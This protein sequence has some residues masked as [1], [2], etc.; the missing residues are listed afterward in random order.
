MLALLATSNGN[1]VAVHTAIRLLH[2]EMH[3]LHHSAETDKIGSSHT[4]QMSMKMMIG[5]GCLA[6]Q[7]SQSTAAT[8][9]TRVQLVNMLRKRGIPKPPM[10]L[11]IAL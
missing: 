11:L 1:C 2:L 8:R 10:P 6:T 5:Q 7:M 3:K 4:M 9:N